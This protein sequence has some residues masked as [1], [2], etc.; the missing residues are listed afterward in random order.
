[1]QTPAPQNLAKQNNLIENPL[2]ALTATF[3]PPSHQ[4]MK[5]M[6]TVTNKKMTW[7]TTQTIY[8]RINIRMTTIAT[9][10]VPTT[11]LIFDLLALSVLV[12]PF[13]TRPIVCLPLQ[14]L[15]LRYHLRKEK[16]ISLS[17]AQRSVGWPSVSGQT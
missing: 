16:P 3:Q 7:R 6:K 14:C 15:H 1:M 5:L 4:A 10:I 9:Q 11:L 17:C 2:V 8:F 13:K 12:P